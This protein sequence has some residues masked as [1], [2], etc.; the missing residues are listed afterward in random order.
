MLLSLLVRI[1]SKHLYTVQR[2]V[3]KCLLDY[4]A[5]AGTVYIK[6][7]VFRRLFVEPANDGFVCLR[8]SFAGG[9]WL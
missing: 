5:S 4:A 1:T 7:I 2:M 3:Y 9:F 6:G 8:P